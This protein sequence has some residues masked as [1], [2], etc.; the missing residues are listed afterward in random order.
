MDINRGDARV[1]MASIHIV[2]SELEN[3]AQAQKLELPKKAMDE[4]HAME[5]VLKDY[6]LNTK[7]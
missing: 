6:Y 4:L 2:I 7:M 1:F 5:H 3:A